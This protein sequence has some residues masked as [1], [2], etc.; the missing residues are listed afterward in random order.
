[1]SAYSKFPRTIVAALVLSIG[2]SPHVKAE[3]ADPEVSKLL[4]Q[5]ESADRVEALKLEREIQLKWSQS[6]SAAMN[7]LLKRGKDALERGETNLAI[8]HFSALIDHAPEFSEG[9]YQRAQ[10]WHQLDKLGLSL[11]DIETTLRLNPNHFEAIF[12]F[13]VVLEQLGHLDLAYRAYGLVQ[14]IHPHY[15]EAAD[16][17]QRLGPRV[18]GRE[19]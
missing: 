17:I 16:A 12:G 19:L 4:G 9:W 3:G 13:G 18:Q 10:A 5:L 6:G 11:S 7:L 14:D 15:D 2:A 1:M 8:E